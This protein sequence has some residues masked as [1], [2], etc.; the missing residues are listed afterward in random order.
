MYFQIFKI[1]P[2]LFKTKGMNGLKEFKTGFTANSK[3][4]ASKIYNKLCQTG[5]SKSNVSNTF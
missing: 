5:T 3:F 4:Q 2:Q 1:R